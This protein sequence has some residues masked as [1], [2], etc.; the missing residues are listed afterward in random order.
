MVEFEG[1]CHNA[2]VCLLYKEIREREREQERER[3]RKRMRKRA[4]EREKEGH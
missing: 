2:A 3:I 1:Y 4:R